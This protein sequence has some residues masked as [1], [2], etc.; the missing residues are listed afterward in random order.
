MRLDGECWE[1]DAD[2][3]VKLMTNKNDDFADWNVWKNTVKAGIDCTVTLER[4]GDDVTVRTENAGV[5]IKATS[6]IRNCPGEIYV[7]LSGDQCALTNI[8][9]HAD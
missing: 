3:D 1:A 8:R 4:K 2:C 9:I 5:Y 7:A 6:I